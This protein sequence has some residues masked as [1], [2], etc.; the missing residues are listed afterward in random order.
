M[1]N[2]RTT[3]QWLSVIERMNTYGARL[4]EDDHLAGG[5][6]TAKGIPRTA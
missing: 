1:R 5:R 6:V 3:E 4:P 2:E